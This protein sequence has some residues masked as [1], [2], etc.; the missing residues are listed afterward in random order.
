MSPRRLVICGTTGCGW[1]RDTDSPEEAETCAAVHRLGH[2]D[3]VLHIQRT[4]SP[5]EACALPD[6][7]RPTWCAICADEACGWE[8]RARTE[9]AAQDFRAVH[10]RAYPD[11]YVTV[12]QF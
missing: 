8:M 2:P 7:A 10:L 9:A 6:L 12:V 3:H 11:H 1:H 4:I 5:E